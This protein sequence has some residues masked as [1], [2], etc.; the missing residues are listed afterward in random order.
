MNKYGSKSLEKLKTCHI[1]LQILFNE[2]VKDFDNTILEGHRGEDA[3][4]KA[5]QEGNSKLQWPHGKHNAIP[6]NAVDAIPYPIDWN[7]LP[8]IYYFAGY[9]LGVAQRLLNE[10][11]ITHKI[12]YGGDWNGSHQ[13]K[14]NIFNDLVHFELLL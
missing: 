8:R 4:N 6:S 3:Q 5:F 9:V 10:G 11:K 14:D 7:D 1:D 13:I 2:V 12:R